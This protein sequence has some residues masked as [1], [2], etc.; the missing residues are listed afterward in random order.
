VVVTTHVNA[1]PAATDSTGAPTVVTF[2]GVER[3]LVDDAT[4][5]WPR[6]FMPQQKTS[7]DVFTAHVWDPPA[8]TD[9]QFVA[10]PT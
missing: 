7:S 10:V 1:C 3:E 8:E 4:A 6:L 5:S 9:R 2:V